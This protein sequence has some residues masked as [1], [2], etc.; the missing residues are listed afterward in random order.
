MASA[1]QYPGIDP[2]IVAC[3]R[4]HAR[5]MA[6][7]IGGMEVEDL[8]QVL[9]LQAHRRLH[10]YDP[11]RAGLRTFVDR[12]ARNVC[13]ELLAAASCE[14]RRGRPPDPPS[15]PWRSI[16][17]HDEG[18]VAADE[19]DAFAEPVDDDWWERVHLRCDV[20]RAVAILPGHL[21]ECC[22]WLSIGGPSEAARRAGLARGS[23]HS[24]VTT[25]RRRF[26]AA[27]LANYFAPPP[28]QFGARP[29]M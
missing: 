6:G 15:S 7:R 9:M 19:S 27:G 1:N 26:I 28:R 16:P 2:D 29:G 4:H 12:V 8:E 22:R 14:R 3:V 13:A 20:D 21:A 24:R 18:S 11:S 25:I 5:R 23:L 10:A 17:T